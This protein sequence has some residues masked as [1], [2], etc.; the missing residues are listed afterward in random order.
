VYRSNL[1]H[2]FKLDPKAFEELR[3]TLEET[4]VH[5]I[6][7]TGIWKSK[8]DVTNFE[9]VYHKIDSKLKELS[10]ASTRIGLF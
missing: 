9:E 8:A 2:E 7:E 1:A 4:L 6:Q 10:A 3:G 5:I